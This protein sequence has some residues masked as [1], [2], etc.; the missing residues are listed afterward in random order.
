[1][2]ASDVA[3][4]KHLIDVIFSQPPTGGEPKLDWDDQLINDHTD[5]IPKNF[6]LVDKNLQVVCALVH[7]TTEVTDVESKE[8]D[9]YCTTTY[10]SKVMFPLSTS[11][12][13]HRN[14]ANVVKQLTLPRAK[15]NLSL[16]V[17]DI[18]NM[19]M[20]LRSPICSNQAAHDHAHRDQT[21]IKRSN[22]YAGEL[23]TKLFKR[24][25]VLCAHAPEQN[26]ADQLK[27]MPRDVNDATSILDHMTPLFG[28]SFRRPLHWTSECS[29]VDDVAKMLCDRDYSML[30]MHLQVDTPAPVSSILEYDGE[31]AKIYTARQAL[32]TLA[33]AFVVAQQHNIELPSVTLADTTTTGYFNGSAILYG[34]QSITNSQISEADPMPV[35]TVNNSHSRCYLIDSGRFD[36]DPYLIRWIPIEL[37]RKRSIDMTRRSK[38][39]TDES[40]AL[41][42]ELGNVIETKPRYTVIYSHRRADGSYHHTQR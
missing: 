14:Q 3:R 1:M 9:Q 27:N 25:V 29:L 32:S 10:A 24:H 16:L 31:H 17:F 2:S 19:D 36:I 41:S 22:F 30:A 6:A 7:S 28:Y 34:K 38:K 33:N 42:V 21:F 35:E 4:I 23:C 5:D 13:S 12:L 37:D 11:R 26:M 39:L 15:R 40:R 8:L 18:M 20:L